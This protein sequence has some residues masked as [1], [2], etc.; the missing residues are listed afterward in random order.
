MAMV[1][2]IDDEP[3]I[4]NLLTEILAGAGHEVRSAANGMKALAAVDGWT[5]EL[6][7]LD[8]NMPQ[9]DGWMFRANQLIADEIAHVPVVILSAVADLADA[10]RTLAPV[11]TLS[12]P[13]EVN[14]I[15]DIVTSVLGTGD[16]AAH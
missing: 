13:F 16:P 4:R 12:K 3:I 8:L 5:P 6:I 2:V 7:L 9:M 15:L 11:A 1:L 10:A 14:D